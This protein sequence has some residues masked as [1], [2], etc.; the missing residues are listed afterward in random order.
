MPRVCHPYRPETK[1]KIEST[2]RYI[3][4]SFWPGIRIDS[5]QDLNCQALIWCQE[6]NRRIHG[7]TREIPLERWTREGFTPFDGH[8]D[9]GT[10]YQSH[11]QVSKDCTFGYRGNRFSV[12]F[13]YVGKNVLVCEGLDTDAIP[14]HSHAAAV[15][16]SP[17][18]MLRDPG[19]RGC[20]QGICM[21]AGPKRTRQ[22]L[23]LG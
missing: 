12:P 18:R 14:S 10:S 23:P 2:I 21:R 16:L 6:A 17:A 4:S 8:P 20:E 13:T 3:K 5:L 1:D 7:T 15:P 22:Q 9:Y 11:R 19:P